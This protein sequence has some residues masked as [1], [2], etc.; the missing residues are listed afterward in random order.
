MKRSIKHFPIELLDEIFQYAA[1]PDSQR[2]RCPGYILQLPKIPDLNMFPLNV[3]SVCTLWL[4]ILKSRP[5]L[6]QR[7][8]INVAS[9]PAPFLDTLDLFKPGPPPD[10]HPRYFMPPTSTTM[11]LIV[12]SSDPTIDKYL[13]RS[14]TRLV[15]KHLVPVIHRYSRIIFRLVYQSSLPASTEIILPRA[16]ENLRELY[17]TCTTYDLCDND[18]DDGDFIG[19][20]D[21]TSFLGTPIP[22][23]LNELSLTGFDFMHLCLSGSLQTKR[24]H[25]FRLSITHYKFQRHFGVLMKFLQSMDAVHY[26]MYIA[27]SDI[28]LDYNPSQEITL[29]YPVSVGKI[30]FDN[31]SADFLS[32]FFSA[33]AFSGV[34]RSVSF[35][36]CVVPHIGRCENLSHIGDFNLELVDIPYSGNDITKPSGTLPQA[37]LD[38]SLFHAM[39][40]FPAQVVRLR[41]CNGVNDKLLSWLAGDTAELEANKM[42]SLNLCDCPNFTAKGICNLIINRNQRIRTHAQPSIFTKLRSIV[43]FGEGPAIY[44]DDLPIL[45]DNHDWEQEGLDKVYVHWNVERSDSHEAGCVTDLQ[46]ITPERERYLRERWGIDRW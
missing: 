27:L 46:P 34:L 23:Y 21:D 28:A 1:V 13:E 36:N 14:R 4:R 29:K 26:G 44:A 19:A 9:N 33:I 32:A 2:Y 38:S 24:G 41:R 17:L 5:R 42:E 8:L 40:A 45:D 3:A 22:T 12:F 15:F 25:N 43:V 31:V 6:W 7:I 39:E 10:P 30:L 11:D 20:N 35:H 37:K 18:V 16:T